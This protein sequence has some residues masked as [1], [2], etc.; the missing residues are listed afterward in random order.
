MGPKNHWKY[1]TWGSS[2]T[3]RLICARSVSSGSITTRT[4]AFGSAQSGSGPVSEPSDP[5]RS[6]SVRRTT[7]STAVGGA[8]TVRRTGPRTCGMLRLSPLITVARSAHAEAEAW[9]RRPR[10]HARRSAG[11]EDQAQGLPGQE[12]RR[13]LLPEG[14]HARLHHSVVRDPRRRA[15]PEE[16]QGQGRRHQPRP[17]REAEEVRRE[18]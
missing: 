2:S 11:E 3:L 17:P 16:A 8:S 13:L 5:R 6:P 9:R 14:R 4:R 12:A 7:S 18:V 15:G 1:G 10:L